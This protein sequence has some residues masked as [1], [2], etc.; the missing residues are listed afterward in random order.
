MIT[1]N[2]FIKSSIGASLLLCQLYTIPSQWSLEYLSMLYRSFN[3]YKKGLEHNTFLQKISQDKFV[4][5][6]IAYTIKKDNLSYPDEA[7]AGIVAKALDDC[8]INLYRPVV[9]FKNDTEYSHVIGDIS[10]PVV[11]LS[12]GTKNITE[13]INFAVYHEIG[14]IANGDHSFKKLLLKEYLPW[15]LSISSS[16]ATTGIFTKKLATRPHYSLLGAL[17]S[18]VFA[19][20]I[21][22]YAHAYIRR[23]E[24]KNADNFAVKQLLKNNHYGAIIATMHHYL[25]MQENMAGE[26]SYKNTHP[27]FAERVKLMIEECEK[28][29]INVND[30]LGKHF[31]PHFRQRVK[32]ELLESISK[33][34]PTM[35]TPTDR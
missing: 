34:I 20:K 8:K 32:N 25:W 30:L 1:F 5:N 28:Q 23:T 24:E 13:E 6:I 12:I 4:G 35:A 15:F 33:F 7:L 21:A 31:P 3:P 18:A 9:V 19:W 14:H 27:P 11:I 10:W 22:P 29:S 2:F 16:I 26:F 17:T